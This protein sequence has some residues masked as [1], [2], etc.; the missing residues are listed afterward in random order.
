MTQ[1]I[2]NLAT[3]EKT[4]KPNDQ[5]HQASVLFLSAVGGVNLGGNMDKIICNRCGH[6]SEI[7][8]VA[9]CV[10]CGS[11]AVRLVEVAK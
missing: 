10:V 6:E 1:T 4:T 11:F 3:D 9:K 8:G 2:K 5:T 7:D